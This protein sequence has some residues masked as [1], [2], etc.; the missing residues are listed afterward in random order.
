MCYNY[1]LS[2]DFWVFVF[3]WVFILLVLV[4]FLAFWDVQLVFLVTDESSGPGGS[5][6]CGFCSLLDLQGLSNIIASGVLG[7]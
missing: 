4:F 2:S 7:F 1:S 5:L 3:A 6:H